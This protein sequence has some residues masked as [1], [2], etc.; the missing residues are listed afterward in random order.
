MSTRNRGPTRNRCHL[1][2]SGARPHQ[3]ARLQPRIP[4]S[5]REDPAAPLPHPL[6][7][8][9]AT[10]GSHTRERRWA[11]LRQWSGKPTL[12]APQQRSRRD[13][14]RGRGWHGAVQQAGST[15]FLHP[16]KGLNPEA[17]F[18]RSREDG[19]PVPRPLRIG[20]ALQRRRGAANP[21]VSHYCCAPGSAFVQ[22]T[23]VFVRID[24]R[25]CAPRS[26]H[27]ARAGG[28]RCRGCPAASPPEQL[29]CAK[30]PRARRGRRAGTPLPLFPHSLW[31]LIC[32]ARKNVARRLKSLWWHRGMQREAMTRALP[33]TATPKFRG[34]PRSRASLCPRRSTTFPDPPQ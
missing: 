26:S 2:G 31:T 17:A 34:G 28:R 33:T 12:C 9:A 27:L 4:K 14:T 1:S 5:L 13:R 3:R 16:Q 10:R 22:R 30:T 7:G 24:P 6:P 23:D 20:G 21:P 32:F 19:H 25:G 29:R 8:L 18:D 15:S 11:E